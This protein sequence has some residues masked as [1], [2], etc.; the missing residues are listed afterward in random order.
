MEGQDHHKSINLGK[1][2][3]GLL[4]VFAGLVYFARAAG[5]LPAYGG[6]H[7]TQLWPVVFIFLGLSLVKTRGAAGVM[8]G[9]AL[10]IVVLGITAYAMFRGQYQPMHRMMFDIEHDIKK[11][12]PWFSDRP[13][14]QDG[15]SNDDDWRMFRYQQ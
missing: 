11:E 6:I 2:F 12:I 9:L 1:I 8:A 10:T 14:G 7:W 13:C 3:L 4:L 5:F 15:I